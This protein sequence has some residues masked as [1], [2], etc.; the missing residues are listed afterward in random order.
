MSRP[1]RIPSRP[2]VVA[3]RRDPFELGFLRDGRL[4]D[5]EPAV[6]E[7]TD[8]SP[9]CR[10][11]AQLAGQIVLDGPDDHR[12]PLPVTDGGREAYFRCAER[13]LLE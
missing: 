10:R 9:E 11:G 2:A 8:R 13:E 3:D 5:S 12:E 1:E 4:V 6:T 7:A